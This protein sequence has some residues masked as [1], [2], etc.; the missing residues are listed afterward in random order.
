MNKFILSGLLLILSVSAYSQ[1]K[2]DSLQT[3]LWGNTVSI[4]EYGAPLTSCETNFENLFKNWNTEHITNA[5]EYQLL[6]FTLV[7]TLTDTARYNYYR[8]Y[9]SGAEAFGSSMSKFN[10]TSSKL[11]TSNGKTYNEE[12]EISERFIWPTYINRELFDQR[13]LPSESKLLFSEEYLQ[14][15]RELLMHDMNID[16]MN[17]I[18][19]S[20]EISKIDT[21]KANAEFLKDAVKS[22]RVVY[23]MASTDSISKRLFEFL[24]KGRMNYQ[25]LSLQE[26]RALMLEEILVYRITSQSVFNQLVHFGDKVYAVNFRYHGALY[27]AYVICNPD[28]KKVVMDNFFK[29]I[30]IRTTM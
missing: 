17:L 27:P 5:R 21:I 4:Y 7:E 8:N 2:Q 23:N 12:I 15:A 11:K 1:T 20:G 24:I 14:Q 10:S 29:N 25:N 19:Y 18:H 9:F 22:M 13:G 28:T 3:L 16:T 30:T 26:K 6:D